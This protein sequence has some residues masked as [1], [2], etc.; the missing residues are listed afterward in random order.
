MH[1]ILSGALASLLLCTAPVLAQGGM[2]GDMQGGGTGGPPGGGGGGGGPP[3]DR[4]GPRQPTPPKPIKRAQFDKVVTAMFREADVNR[5]GMVMIAELRGLFDAR[6]ETL[7]RARF[8]KIDSNHNGALSYEE[9][10]AWQRQM[11]S[12]ASSEVA[13]T[14]DRGGPIAEVLLPDVGDD[15]GSMS[16]AAL[17]E[18][19]SVGLITNANSNYDAGLSLE[20]LLA[21]QGKRFDAADANHDGW[22]TMDELRPPSRGGKAPRGSGGPPCLPDRPC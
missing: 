17:I 2:G 6:R 16:L 12:V 19:L 4:G 9:F 8:A 3:G 10:V 1:K 20:E 21:Y 14:G 7:I 15:P 13:G 5:D 11:G 22:L 18:P